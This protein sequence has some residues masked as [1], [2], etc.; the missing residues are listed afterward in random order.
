M[1]KKT[2]EN[3]G[4]PFETIRRNQKYCCNACYSIANSKRYQPK[5]KKEA[6]SKAQNAK[7]KNEMVGQLCWYCK[8]AI[9]NCSW[10]RCFEP[11][12]GWTAKP[13]TIKYDETLTK[14]YRITEC[15]EF[16]RG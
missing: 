9:G 5:P 11:V 12:K 6:K 16:I 2:C 7:P 4:K 10:S 3:C 14:S 8:N 1:L 13:T 15:P